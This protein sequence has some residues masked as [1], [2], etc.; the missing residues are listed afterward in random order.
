LN[1]EGRLC[2]PCWGMLGEEVLELMRAER[3]LQSYWSV[4]AG[5]ACSLF[6]IQS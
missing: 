3:A 1:S 5:W 2:A 6:S 4:R